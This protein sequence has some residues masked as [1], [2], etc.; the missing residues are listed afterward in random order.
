MA[1]TSTGVEALLSQPMATPPAL[2]QRSGASTIG[3]S[4]ATANDPYSAL[5]QELTSPF[6]YLSTGIES[7]P[8]GAASA[9]PSLFPATIKDQDPPLENTAVP[10]RIEIATQT[11]GSYILPL[12]PMS[13]NSSGSHHNSPQSMFGLSDEELDPDWLNFLDEASPLFNEIDMPSP[14]PSGDEGTPTSSSNNKSTQRDK[15]LWSWAEELL[16]PGATTPTG[17]RGFPSSS[18]TMSSIPGS[19]GGGGLVRTLQGASQQKV[20][21]T[22]TSSTISKTEAKSP[23]DNKDSSEENSDKKEEKT[24]K[25]AGIKAEHKSAMDHSA[26]QSKK[27]QPEEKK[28][29]GFGGLIAMLRNL[30]VGKSEGN[31]DK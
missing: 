5:I 15:T 20:N 16:K 6:G 12:S 7:F 14:P 3:V 9:W 30:W 19:I 8:E 22:A 23:G 26:A 2:Q 29:D 18:A 27:P 28:E 31:G 25:V 17:N 11:D 21:K 10:Q 13:A 24:G 1:V 4:V